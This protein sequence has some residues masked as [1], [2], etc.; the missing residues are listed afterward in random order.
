MCDQTERRKID[1]STDERGDSAREVSSIKW[2]G[3]NEKKEKSHLGKIV[4]GVEETRKDIRTPTKTT[5]G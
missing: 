5:L 1:S 3:E 4:A 2:D